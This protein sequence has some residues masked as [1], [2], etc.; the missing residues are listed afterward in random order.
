MHSYKMGDTLLSN[1]MSEKDLGIFVD[2]K[3]SMSQKC[4]VAAK[5]ANAILTEVLY[6]LQIP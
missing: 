6:S 5:K 2:Q 1:T 3:L 4:D